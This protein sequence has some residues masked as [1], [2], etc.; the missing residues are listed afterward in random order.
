MKV[1]TCKLFGVSLLVFN[2]NQ[3]AAFAH[4]S[5]MQCLVSFNMDQQL[6]YMQ[7]YSGLYVLLDF[8]EYVL[9]HFEQVIETFAVIQDI[10]NPSTAALVHRAVQDF[11]V[12]M[13]ALWDEDPAAIAE[14]ANAPASFF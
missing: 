7:L 4:D 10:P 13:L 1:K 6:Q 3:I 14:L 8:M 11:R 5:S 12:V 9:C 2:W